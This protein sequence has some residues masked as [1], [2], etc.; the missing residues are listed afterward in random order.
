MAATTGRTIFW[1]AA[2]LAV[3][4][5]SFWITLQILDYWAPADPDADLIR[6]T[7][8]TYGMNCRGTAA[9]SGQVSDVKAGNATVA[10]AEGC[11]GARKMCSF[12]VDVRRLGDPAPGCGKDLSVFWRCGAD[13]SIRRAYVAAEANAQMA[14]LACP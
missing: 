13:E 9:R 2:G 12:V 6:V 1:L 7:E 4:A 14:R 5:G 11:A 8:A 10:I 3:L